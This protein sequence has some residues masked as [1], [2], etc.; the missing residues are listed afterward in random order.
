MTL[1]KAMDWI[2]VLG[3]LAGTL[4][5]ISFWPQLYKTWT[6]K[7]AEDVSMGMVLTFSLGVLLWLVYGMCLRAWPII[8]TN[9]IT[10]AMTA[11]IAVLKFRYHVKKQPGEENVAGENIIASGWKNRSRGGR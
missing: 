4:T 1:L 5:T 8:V 9:A 11:T 2:T 7:S 10:V 3:F 6:T